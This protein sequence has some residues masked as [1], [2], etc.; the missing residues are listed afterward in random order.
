MDFCSFGEHCTTNALRQLRQ[1]QLKNSHFN[2]LTMTTQDLFGLSAMPVHLDAA[3]TLVK[4][5]TGKPCDLQG[6]CPRN[7]WMHN[8]H[9]SRTSTKH[10]V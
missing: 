2:Q 1:S 4:E 6:L 10:W 3:H 8:T 5:M 9:T 7:S